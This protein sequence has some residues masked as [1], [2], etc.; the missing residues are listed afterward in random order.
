MGLRMCHLNVTKLTKGPQE[1]PSNYYGI[2][3]T[4]DDIGKGKT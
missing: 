2:N 1:F 3:H 4:L